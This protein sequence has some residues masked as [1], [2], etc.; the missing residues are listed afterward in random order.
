MLSSEFVAS[1]FVAS[2]RDNV[3]TVHNKIAKLVDG[4]HIRTEA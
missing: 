4:V 2:F 1:L 3:Y